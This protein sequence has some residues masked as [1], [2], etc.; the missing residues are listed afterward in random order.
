M[1]NEYKFSVIK[2]EAHP[3]RDERLN[4]GIAV[5]KEHGLDVRITRRLT[6]LQSISS[7][8]DLDNLR[9]ALDRLSET[10]AH[11][12]D[13][14]ISDEIDLIQ[15][16]SQISVCKLIPGG[17]FFAHSSGEYE[18]RIQQLMNQLVD[19]EKAQVVRPK[20]RRT[21]VKRDIEDR[22]KKIGIL[23]KQGDE[24]ETHRVVPNHL[25]TEGVEADLVLKN[26]AYHILETV[27]VQD[28]TSSSKR[29]FSDIGLTSIVFEHAKMV[30]GKQHIVPRLIYQASAQS[31]SLA[32]PA[33]AAVEHQGAELVNWDSTNDRNRLIDIL[34]NLAASDPS[35]D[36][37]DA[38]TKGR[39]ELN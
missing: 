11:L 39:V 8:V 32:A 30:Y 16:L 10:F 5:S 38:S 36:W 28:E 22:L 24:L 2:F 20:K 29:I 14:S 1:G 12:V 15:R 4:V 6:K 33:L 3:V 7:A 26:G 23:G 17:S 19:P 13:N 31:E 9:D 25:I 34:A 35:K 21:K 27:D 37:I 18:A